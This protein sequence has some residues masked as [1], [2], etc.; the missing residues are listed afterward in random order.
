MKP[1]LLLS[2]AATIYPSVVLAAAKI[3][4]EYIQKA[5]LRHNLPVNV[6][7]P[8]EDL[9]PWVVWRDNKPLRL[10]NQQAM[11][12]YLSVDQEI[13]FGPWKLKQTEFP[14]L[15]HSQL[16]DPRV[17]VELVA[18]RYVRQKMLASQSSKNHEP[19]KTY[20]GKYADIIN[21]AGQK[22][23]VDPLLIASVIRQESSYRAD[24]VSPKGARGLMQVMPNTARAMGYDPDHMF[25]PVIGI[26]A[27]TRYL[28]TQ[29]KTFGNI[30]LALA[31]YNAGPG[32]V[33]KY[34]KNIPPFQET[35]RY[36]A[37]IMKNYNG[38]IK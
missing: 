28:S 7:M 6:I 18:R 15:K 21:K 27:G 13:Q 38:V 26:D 22:Y 3:V 9:W 36:V 5:A 23:N 12:R 8:N 24:A 19:G 2:L 1:F 33:N 11:V 35:K 20:T 37:K 31:A 4:P 32:A 30:E 34:G 17:Q 14:N 10:Q 16:S 25:D 29:L